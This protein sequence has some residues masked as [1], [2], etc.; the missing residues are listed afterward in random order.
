VAA[1]AYDLTTDDARLRQLLAIPSA[2][3]AKYFS[4]LRATYPVRREFQQ[5][6]IPNGG[7]PESYREAVEEGLTMQCR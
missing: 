4:R 1:Q 6:T 2:E 7:V 5:H 3:R